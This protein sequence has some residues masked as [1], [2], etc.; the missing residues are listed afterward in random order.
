MDL[1]ELDPHM[2]RCF[3]LAWQ[4]CALGTVGVGA[5]LVDADGVVL[6]DGSNGLF[7]EPVGPLR[8]NKIAHA[9]MNALAQIDAARDLTR[10]T[11]Y[12]SLEPCFMCAGA[13]VLARIGRVV[14]AA[15]DPYMDGAS[16]LGAGAHA[17]QDRAERVFLD[18]ERWASLSR[19]LSLHAVFFWMAGSDAVVS[20]HAA[21]PRIAPLVAQLVAENTLA[22]LADD[23]VDL[24]GVIAELG[25]RI[26]QTLG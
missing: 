25:P 2:A 21:E 23:G 4:S 9:E 26:A 8:G 19:V 5:R 13:V 22:A 10:A 20:A 11:L 6:A 14:I 12:T 18:D 15:R 17:M 7:A 3:E 1:G 24:A 16:S